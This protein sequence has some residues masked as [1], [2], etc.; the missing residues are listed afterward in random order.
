MKR[1]V[2]ARPH[3]VEIEEVKKP[4]PAAGEVLVR[5]LVTGISAGTEMGLYRGTN[6]ELVQRR[7]GHQGTYPVNP[8]Y[9]SVGVVS[10]L[11][12]GVSGLSVGDRILSYGEHAQ[13]SV[14]AAPQA[15]RLPDDLDDET[16]TLAVMGTTALHGVRR[17]A[18]EYGD[19][20]AV[21]GMGVVGQFA[22]QHARLAGAAKT[23]AVDLDPW[24][25]E[26]AGRLGATHTVN[27]D[28]EDPVEAVL[29][30]TEIGADAV[31]EAAGVPSAVPLALSLA[32]DGGR[33]SIV[34]W[35]LRPVELVLAEDFLY[36][37]LDVRASRGPGPPEGA[38][39]ALVRW[40]GLRNRKTVVQL[41][42]DG[43]LRT[44]GLITHVMPFQEIQRAYELILTKSEPWLQVVLRWADIGSEPISR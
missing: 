36:K 8:G 2:I 9:E 25:T 38:S 4:A 39:P 43:R 22:I 16:A 18:V 19:T 28:V 42:A 34:G 1:V 23:I 12:P 3:H 14:V 26:V 24:R 31:I 27:P 29:G 13:Y 37:E 32:R 7:W 21:V 40:T 17:A 20:V 10:E 35:H 30:Y 5:T 44:E 15:V 11:G 41:L 6:P 33:V